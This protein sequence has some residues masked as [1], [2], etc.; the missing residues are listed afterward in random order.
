VW[1]SGTW[2]IDSSYFSAVND[3]YNLGA[4]QNSNLLGYAPTYVT[5]KDIVNCTIGFGGNGLYSEGEIRH[6]P[7]AFITQIYQDGAWATFAMGNLRQIA[8]ENYA[9]EAM[10][11]TNWIQVFNGDSEVL[12]L[13]GLPIVQGYTVSMGCYPVQQILNGGSF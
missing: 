13:N 3:N 2:L 9:L 10:P 1:N 12:G 4:D 5:D 11:L 7:N 8:A 6:D